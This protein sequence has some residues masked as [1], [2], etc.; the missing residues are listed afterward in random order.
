[1]TTPHGYARFTVIVYTGKNLP[2]RPTLNYFEWNAPA[3]K[4]SHGI[5]D[6]ETYDGYH[7]HTVISYACKLHPC[8]TR[9]RDL[10]LS[11]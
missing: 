11:V 3:A 5:I 9:D 6:E 7:R 2:V 1:M 4:E 8:V 10:A